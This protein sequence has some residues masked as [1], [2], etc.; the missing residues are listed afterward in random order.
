MRVSVGDKVN[1]IGDI[2][3]YEGHFGIVRF[4]YEYNSKYDYTACIVDFGIY[5]SIVVSDKNLIS[6]GPYHEK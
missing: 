3:E 6:F 2:F 5:N 1:Y 4:Q